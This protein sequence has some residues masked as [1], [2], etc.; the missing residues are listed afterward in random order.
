[1]LAGTNP[2]SLKSLSGRRFPC[3]RQAVRD[4]HLG[5]PLSGED[6]M[7]LRKLPRDKRN[8]LIAVIAS[9][10]SIVVGMYLLLD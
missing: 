10:L 4:V 8:K 2:I 5:M 9:A 6:A 3:H 1:M 7:N